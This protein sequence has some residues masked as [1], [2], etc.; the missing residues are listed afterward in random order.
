ME[1]A[2]PAIV[3]DSDRRA[4][5]QIMINLANNAIKFTETGTVRVRLA[6]RHGRRPA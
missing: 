4:L 6:Q 3:I 2:E 5:T 1:L